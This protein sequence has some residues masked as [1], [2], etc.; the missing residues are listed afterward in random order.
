MHA[1]RRG[2]TMTELL[3]VVAVITILVAMMSPILL[4]AHKEASR[5]SCMGNLRQ[6]YTAFELIRNKRF[7][8]F[9]NCFES[10]NNVVDENSWWYRKVAQEIYPHGVA[11][12]GKHYDHLTVP[13]DD[14]KTW[15]NGAANAHI[16]LQSFRPEST[17]LRCPATPDHPDD[18][19]HGGGVPRNTGGFD[20][21]RV[22][23]D[24]YGYNN[25]GFVYTGPSASRRVDL[26][27]A[28]RRGRTTM[29][30]DGGSGVITGHYDTDPTRRYTYVGDL[31]EFVGQPGTILMMDYV[32]ADIAPNID[33]WYGFRFRHGDRANVL[34]ADGRIEGYRIR[35]LMGEIASDTIRWGVRV[36]GR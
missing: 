14:D 6:I 2:M 28:V 31:A 30:H 9:P 19:V 10:T 4:R 27:T 1:R 15:W 12:D 25:Y 18:R 29:Y 5:R 21:H 17:F 7:G 35:S 3:T 32:K 16:N 36:P 24:N 34:F 13:Y 20:K 26:A 22:F 8:K 23:D 33:E 11:H